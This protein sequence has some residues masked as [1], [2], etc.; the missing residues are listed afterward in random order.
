MVKSSRERHYTTHVGYCWRYYCL[1]PVHTVAEKCDCR[2]KRRENDDSHTT[3][4]AEFGDSRQ[5]RQIVAE[6]GDYSRQCGQAFRAL[7]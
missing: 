1:S 4:V 2:R 6:I 3:T 7:T 5:S